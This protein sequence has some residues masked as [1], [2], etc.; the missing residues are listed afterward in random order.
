MSF[1]A[2]GS[3]ATMLWSGPV[4]GSAR[5]RPQTSAIR[6]AIVMS[7]SGSAMQVTAS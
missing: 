2:N 6:H 5:R 1:H 4:V 3:T 7:L